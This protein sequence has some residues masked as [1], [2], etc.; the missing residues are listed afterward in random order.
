MEETLFDIHGNAVA[1]ISYDNNNTIYLWNGRPVAYLE[2][3][4][5]IYGFNGQH[6][7][8]F[9]D[10]KVRNLKGEIVGFNR[11]GADVYLSYEPY[12]SYKQ[13]CP[14]RS[15]KQY[16]HYKPYYGYSKALESLAQFLSNGR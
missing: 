14:Y 3:D 7:G 10:G 15:Y 13:Y 16:A 9:E 4:N 5:T 6:L 1:Y 12:K 8:W 11:D 2:S